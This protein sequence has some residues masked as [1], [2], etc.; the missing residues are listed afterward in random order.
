M[1][2]RIRSRDKDDDV[3]LVVKLFAL[4]HKMSQV[5]QHKVYITYSFHVTNVLHLT[6]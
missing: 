3:T 4:W 1:A 2:K 6:R 5:L